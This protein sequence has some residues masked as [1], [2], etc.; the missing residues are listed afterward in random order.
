ML[1]VNDLMTAI[2][3]TVA[4]STPLR[5]VIE[6]MKVE[7]CRQLPVLENGDLVGIITDRDI[8]LVMCSPLALHGCGQNE[9]LLDQ[10]TA[11]GCMTRNPMTVPPDMPAYQ[12]AHLLSLYKFGALPVVDEEVLVGIVTVTDFLDYFV[13]GQAETNI[14]DSW[15]AGK[16]AEDWNHLANT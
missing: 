2:P 4:T 15:S 1:L 13:A 10:T 16:S 11:G 5:H 9:E 6:V 8:R 7:G 3:C 14:E 12:A